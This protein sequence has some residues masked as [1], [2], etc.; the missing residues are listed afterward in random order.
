MKKTD[1]NQYVDQYTQS[2][3]AT[4][5]AV[6]KA[7][8]RIVITIISLFFITLLIVGIFMVS[9][10]MS[11]RDE[12]I[13][14]DLHSLKLNYTSFI[15]VANEQGDQQEYKRLY[16]GESNRV[17]VDYQDIP[18]HMKN[19]MVAIE[20]KRFWEHGGVDWWR[21][22]GAAGNLLSKGDSYGGSTITQQLIKNLTG[23]NDVSITRKLKEIFRAENLEKNYSKEEILECYLNVVNFGSGCKGVQAAA[24][25]YF[26]KDI[27]NCSLAE[28]AAIAGI[29]QNPYAYT[30]MIFPEKN[31]ERQQTVLTAMYDQGKITEQEYNEAMTESENMQFVFADR[32]DANSNTSVHNW[33][34]DTMI[35]DVVADLQSELGY[36]EKEAQDMIYYG[37]LKIYSAM[38]ADTQNMAEQAVLNNRDIKSDSDMQ[39]GVYMMQ[40]DGRVL[41]IVGS[42]SEKQGNLWFNYATDALRSPGS[43]MKPLA[44]YAPA[45]DSGIISY[46]SL[47]QDQP[48]EGYFAD[49][50]A[51]PNNY[52]NRFRGTITVQNAIQ[53]SYNP[54][55]VR[56]FQQLGPKNV[57]NF[58]TKKLGFM[59]LVNGIDD[60]NLSV[61]IGGVH[62]GVTVK[63]MTAGYQIFGN[64]GQYNK[65]YTYYYVEDHNGNVILDNRNLI[66]VQAVQSSTA[67]V[68]QKL[69]TTVV[70]SG[71]GTSAAI[72]GWQIFGKTG[73]TDI[74]DNSYFVGGSPYAVMGVW[75]GYQNPSRLRNTNA[76][77]SVFRDIMAAYLN[78][79]QLKQFEADSSV[80]SSLYFTSTGSLAGAN[81]PSTA[82]GWYAKNNMPSVC[83]LHQYY[84]NFDNQQDTQ[85]S[86][87]NH[88]SQVSVEDES[89]NSQASAD[90][91]RNLS[92][93]GQ[94]E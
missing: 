73:T 75:T 69:L 47:V 35:Q 56:V 74:D 80:V 25:L 6:G 22:I 26:G 23:E 86:E 33:Y 65:P 94:T 88:S 81:C 89:H 30:P 29:T 3:N 12:K 34:I 90:G 59:N 85:E 55:A 67:T 27:K 36:G 51:G 40:Y 54:P 20:D 42:R 19:A 79:K 21:T 37:G 14:I 9:F 15:Y 87:N 45:I 76:S 1:I 18:Q 10:V 44:A 68:M 31:K 46:S 57:Y 24:H 91:D 43:S 70:T 72:P 63:E 17:W 71:T 28:C 38:D 13:D 66:S 32:Q 82:T 2:G 11:L 61:S 78:T 60:S 7:I 39:C 48:I 52:D 77:K 58:L 64:G 83:T 4:G 62:N 16:G 8:S 41:A 84:E 49:G 93:V 53:Q 5:K 92:S 50:T